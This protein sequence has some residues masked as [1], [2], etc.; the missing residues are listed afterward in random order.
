MSE[1]KDG[2]P[3]AKARALRVGSQRRV[4]IPPALLDE[5]GATEGDI[6]LV[7]IRKARVEAEEE[8][9]GSDESREPEIILETRKEE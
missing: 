2:A 5:I 7:S 4:I 9:A 1:E 6:V 3:K 8:R